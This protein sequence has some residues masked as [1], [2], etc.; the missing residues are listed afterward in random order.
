MGKE[1]GSVWAGAAACAAVS[2]ALAGASLQH[3]KRDANLH[4]KAVAAPEVFSNKG[5]G[6]R[7]VRFPWIY[8]R[9]DFDEEEDEDEDIGL[10]APYELL[11][12]GPAEARKKDP[13]SKRPD[14]SLG[15]SCK[16]FRQQC[17]ISCCRPRPER[18]G[19]YRHAHRE[20]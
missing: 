11:K 5:H 15:A 12:L 17:G 2:L 18:G 6:K 1:E 20:D 16:E 19:T 3:N 10:P 13:E 8:R 9:P 7:K 4:T 14:C